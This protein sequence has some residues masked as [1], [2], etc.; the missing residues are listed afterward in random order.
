MQPVARQKTPTHLEVDLHQFQ[1][2]KVLMTI[3]KY[4]RNISE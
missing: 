3:A 2:R 4:L 1:T